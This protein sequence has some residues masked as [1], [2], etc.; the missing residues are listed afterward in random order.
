MTVKRYLITLPVILISILNTSDA[1]EDEL[2]RDLLEHP[3][4]DVAQLDDGDG[5]GGGGEAAEHAADPDLDPVEVAAAADLRAAHVEAGVAR[6]G[7]GLLHLLLLQRVKLLL[8]RRGHRLLL[9]SLGQEISPTFI[10]H[11]SKQ[12]FNKINI[13]SIALHK[14]SSHI[15][16]FIISASLQYYYCLRSRPGDRDV[17][18]PLVHQL[19][20]MLKLNC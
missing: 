6:P 17:V 8:G 12:S 9:A 3:E 15:S 18:R 16:H 7:R 20:V 19:V 1:P 13:S 2:V 14:T 10:I 5:A 4:L 11:L